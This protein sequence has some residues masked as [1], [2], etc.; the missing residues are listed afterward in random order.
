MCAHSMDRSARGKPNKAVGLALLT[1]ILLLAAASMRVPTA[2]A[3]DL[4]IPIDLPQPN[5]VGF[6]IGAG[7]RDARGWIVAMLHLSPKW[8]LGAGVMYSRLLN[9]AKDS[10]IVSERGD[11]D[12]WVYGAGAMYAW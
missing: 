11:A 2:S 6:G 7:M 4:V 10:P 8:H 5:F 12:Q 9:D 3:N 1:A